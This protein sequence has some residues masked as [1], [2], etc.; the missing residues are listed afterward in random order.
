MTNTARCSLSFVLASL[1]VWLFATIPLAA[2]AAD[3]APYPTRPIKLLVGAPAG[4]PPDIVARTLTESLLPLLGQAVIVENR[5]GAGTMIAAESAARAKPDGYTLH[6]STVAN[7]INQTMM[8][9]ENFDFGSSLD[10]IA[11]ILSS[12]SVL[13]VRA[14]SD[15]ESLQDL[16]AQARARPHA[17]NYGSGGV[18]TSS[19]LAME[20]MT[21]RQGV[22]LTHIPYQSPQLFTDLL[23]GAIDVMFTNPDAALP[24]IKAGKV[25]ALGVTTTNRLE[26]LP[27]VPTLAEQGL[28]GYEVST[29]AGISAPAGLPPS[30]RDALEAAILKAAANPVFAEKQM[31]TGNTISPL[32]SAEFTRFVHDDSA[33][34]AAVIRDA[35]LTAQ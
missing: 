11:R 28:P 25:R 20:L 14:D 6:L 19:H 23:G 13:I 21:A 4:S 8:P 31:L 27:N 3:A 26:S 29:W 33:K 16:T 10:H 35:G 9:R 17:L 32:S 15:I 30:V 22:H 1:I 12:G 24:L 18:G 2:S 7:A 34:W 5:P